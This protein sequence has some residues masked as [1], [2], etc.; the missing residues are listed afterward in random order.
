MTIW[1]PNIQNASGALYRRLADAIA[2]D[3]ACGRLHPGEKL[4]THRDLAD[5][6]GINVSTVTKG[7]REAEQRGLIAGTVGRGTYVSSDANVNTPMVSPESHSSGMIEL[8][9]INPLYQLDP[10]LEDGL[11]KICRRRDISA[12]MHYSD[13]GG[14]P[15]HRAV[16]AEWASRFGLH[17]SAAGISICSG[18]QHGLNCVLAGLFRPGDRIA[19][20]CLTY[21]GIKTLAAMLEIRLV[22]VEMD[23]RGMVA[24]SLDRICRREEIKGVYLIPGVHN[25]TTATISADRRRE[26]SRVIKKHALL[27]IEDDAYDLTRPGVIPPLSSLLPEQ[28]IYIAGISKALAAGLRVAFVVVPE[29]YRRAIHEAILNTMWMTPPL[30]IEL[31]TMWIKDGTADRVIAAKRQEA[32]RRFALAREILHDFSFT[33]IESGFYIWLDLPAPWRGAAFE[34]RMRELGVNVFGAEKFIVGD[35]AAPAA[36]RISLSGARSMAELRTGLELINRVLSNDQ[37][38]DFEI[39]M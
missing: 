18:A 19:T 12:L 8:G 11:K 6:L 30:N 31:I 38:E 14:R 36:A 4:P 35:A 7:Y 23:H 9:L 10:S 21:P 13:P 15:E 1:T 33:G 5:I 17:S 37:R 3:I 22:P 26:L 25:P 29:Q 34:L 20:D 28:G 24:E 32:S 39:T 16:G 2:G 27:V